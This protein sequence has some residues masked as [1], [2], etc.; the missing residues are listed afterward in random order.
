[1]SDLLVRMTGLGTFG[2]PGTAEQEFFPWPAAPP[3]PAGLV[4][5][6][7]PP[8]ARFPPIS[9]TV[10]RGNAS[11]LVFQS[12]EIGRGARRLGPSEYQGRS[13]GQG[14]SGPQNT[15]V[16]QGAKPEKFGLRE[17]QTRFEV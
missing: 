3:C 2:F 15:E 5:V 12:T 6:F 1:M 13:G 4:L 10:V 17:G 8:Q 14:G 16:G 11:G 7:C 9:I